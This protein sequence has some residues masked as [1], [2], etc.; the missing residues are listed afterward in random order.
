MPYF[1]QERLLKAQARGPLTD[2]LYV[3]ALQ[4]TTTFARNFAPLF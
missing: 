4:S 2:D 3:R 1:A